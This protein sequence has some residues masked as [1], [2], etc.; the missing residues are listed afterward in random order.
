MNDL[1]KKLLEAIDKP[2]FIKNERGI[3]IACNSSFEKFLGIDRCNIVGQTA[4]ALAPNSLAQIYT[5]ADKELFA[6]RTVQI[7]KAPAPSNVQKREA[8]IF[9]KIIY[10]DSSDQVAG[11]IGTVNDAKEPA[12]LCLQADSL[13]PTKPPELT[14]REFEVLYLMSQGLSAKEI[15]KKL[16]VSN[17]TIADHAKSIYTKL[18]ANNRVSAILAAQ[19]FHLI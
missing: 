8:V 9:S 2:A 3:Y 14:R 1:S 11:F 7:Y 5:D 16:I 13:E 4:F 15:A 19:K 6:K 17:H 18:G 12:P 10:F